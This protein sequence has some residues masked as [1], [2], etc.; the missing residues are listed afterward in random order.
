MN[1]YFTMLDRYPKGSHRL[2]GY[3]GSLIDF[4]PLAPDFVT[5]ARAMKKMGWIYRNGQSV[6]ADW[7]KNQWRGDRTKSL[8]QL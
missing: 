6:Y 1:G 8:N 7:E 3:K 5:A 4:A 2:G